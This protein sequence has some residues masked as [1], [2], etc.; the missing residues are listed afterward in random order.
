MS[1]QDSFIH[2]VTEEV[3]RDRMFRLWK[4]YGPYV[5]G[6]L[7][8]IVAVTAGLQYLKHLEREA[9]RDAGVSLIEAARETD[10][11]RRAERFAATLDGADG[12]AAVLAR[13]R[14]AAASAQSGDLERAA[15]EYQ[16]LADDPATPLPLAEFAALR[17]ILVRAPLTGTLDTI[18]AL[19]PFTAADSAFRLLALEARGVARMRAADRDGA[20]ADFSEVLADP[21]ATANMRARVEQFQRI[22]DARGEGS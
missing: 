1:D 20:Q 13:L 8:A 9:A 14:L 6:V 16:I 12:G 10:P 17:A 18:D 21:A 5:I 4:R 19:G 7:V 3:R 15:N 11:A 22:L 2:E